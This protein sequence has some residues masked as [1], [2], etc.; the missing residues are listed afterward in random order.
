M[1]FWN[2]D[3]GMGNVKNSF[4]RSAFSYQPEKTLLADSGLLKAD[5]FV[6]V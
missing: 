4:Q 1:G 3:F 5:R 2:G 6:Y